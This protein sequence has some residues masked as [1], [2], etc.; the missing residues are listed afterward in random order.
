MKR[1]AVLLLALALGSCAAL[2]VGSSARPFPAGSESERRLA[3]G[4]LAI[5]SSKVNLVDASRPTQANG[6]YAGDDKRTLKGRVWHPADKLAGPYPLVVY[7]HGFSSYHKVGRYIAEHLASL[8]HVVVAVDYP[9]TKL[10]APGGPLVRDVVNQP[11]DVSFLIDTL[12]AQSA[13]EGHPLQGMIDGTRI[14]ATGISLGGMTTTL[15]AFH[16]QLRDPRIKAALAIAGPMEVFTRQFFTHTDVPFLML[17]GD[18]DAMVPYAG[19]AAR[20]PALVPG[21]QLV[22]V[23]GGSH[24]GFADPATRLQWVSNPDALGCFFVKDDVA[25]EVQEPWDGL[26]GAAEIGINYEVANGFCQLDPLPK[27]MNPLRQHMI[28]KVVV[29]SF[30]QAH[31]ATEQA[32]REAA[33]RYLSEILASELEDVSYTGPADGQGVSATGPQPKTP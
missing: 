7:S 13:T 15:A 14:G 4:P 26:F 5:S 10:N 18:N 20:V 25:A 2:N 28:T 30:F 21:G 3:P 8:G 11:G 16:P 27:A 12:L 22:T 23:H 9:L 6:S 29:G 19:N 17:A 24:T 1:L 33:R 32:D 31:F